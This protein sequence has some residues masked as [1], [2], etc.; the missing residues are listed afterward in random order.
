M[1]AHV[2]DEPGGMLLQATRGQRR[3]RAAPAMQHPR[4]PGDRKA[5][6][7]GD[8]PSGQVDV[9]PGEEVASVEHA[10]L[11]QRVRPQQ[12]GGGGE[13]VDAFTLG[14]GVAGATGPPTEATTAP[15][16]HVLRRCHVVEHRADGTDARVGVG[17][18]EQFPHSRRLDQ[19]VV[20]EHPDEF[21][22]V[23]EQTGDGDVVAS[24]ET[25]VGLVRDQLDVGY[26]GKP[27]G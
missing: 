27:G 25:E 14:A 8:E 13:V 15:G 12:D 20:V 4:P 17:D 21:E 18:G 22:P 1:D 19:G 10:H 2:D 23:V 11:A 3:K 16:Q 5:P 26:G 24:G 9:L 7:A 6:A